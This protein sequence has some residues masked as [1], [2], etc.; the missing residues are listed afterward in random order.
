MDAL[1]LKLRSYRGIWNDTVSG[2]AESILSVR[3]RA[4][5]VCTGKGECPCKQKQAGTQSTQKRAQG[6]C[7]GGMRRLLKHEEAIARD[8]PK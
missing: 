7:D 6:Y 5:L 4:T 8:E 2:R 1:R 3:G